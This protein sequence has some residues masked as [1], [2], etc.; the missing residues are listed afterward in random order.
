MTAQYA[1]SL[2]PLSRPI[3]PLPASEPQ[4]RRLGGAQRTALKQRQSRRPARSLVVQTKSNEG[5]RRATTA[6]STYVPLRD[7]ALQSDI[8]GKQIALMQH[9][10]FQTY[11]RNSHNVVAAI[12][13]FV[14]LS[15][16]AANATSPT[17]LRRKAQV[18]LS[19][20]TARTWKPNAT[21]QQSQ[22]Q[23][24]ERYKRSHSLMFFP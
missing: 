17:K 5:R 18:D 14:H 7:L 13:D 12:D 9:Y 10:F 3:E 16:S 2:Q 4:K 11:N 20:G 6:V 8:G 15:Y 23:N 1:Q 21:Y 19:V 22:A 24:I